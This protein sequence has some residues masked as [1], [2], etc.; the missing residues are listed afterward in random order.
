MKLQIV[1]DKLSGCHKKLQGSSCK[2]KVEA[3]CEKDV[4]NKQLNLIAHLDV[5]QGENKVLQDVS[6]QGQKQ[7]M[8]YFVQHVNNYI[9]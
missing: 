3:L 5:G 4:W 8:I 1:Y 7:F 9:I 6:A 2:N